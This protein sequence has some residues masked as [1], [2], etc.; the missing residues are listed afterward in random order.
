[1]LKSGSIF[2]WCTS[3]FCLFT[4]SPTGSLSPTSVAVSRLEAALS[5]VSD[6]SSARRHGP[7]Y[8]WT[9]LERIW[10]QAGMTLI[11][12]AITQVFKCWSWNH[13]GFL[14]TL[15]NHKVY[16]ME[17]LKEQRDSLHVFIDLQLKNN[18][19]CGNFSWK[20]SSVI[21]F[22]FCDSHGYEAEIIAFPCPKR[23]P[24]KY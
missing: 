6:M 1:M 20:L 3:S 18:W 16:C 10:L 7:T 21:I 23:P 4:H 8:I 15:G 19:L 13:T 22:Q 12:I 24:K 5:E 17:L 9:T 14:F 2:F 11:L